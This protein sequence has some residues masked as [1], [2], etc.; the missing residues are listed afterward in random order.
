MTISRYSGSLVELTVPSDV[1]IADCDQAE[2]RSWGPDVRYH[3]GPGQ[4]DRLWILEP[5]LLPNDPDEILL[6][7][8]ISWFPETDPSWVTDMQ[9]MVDSLWLEQ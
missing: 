1:V 6:I 2:Y 7:V 5:H 9:A 3:Q 8:D 4:I